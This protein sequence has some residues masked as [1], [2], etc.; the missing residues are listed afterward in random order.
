MVDEDGRIVEGR[1]YRHYE[2]G[3]SDATKALRALTRAR[4]DLVGT[5]LGLAN[6]LRAQLGCF[7]A[8]AA[9]VFADID[10]P[11]ALAFLK[12]YP[13]PVDARGLGEQRMARFLTRHGYS[14]RRTP[15]RAAR[16]VA[17]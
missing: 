6:E 16:A 3:D 5:R 4:E 12:R 17:Q 1:R 2:R 9:E 14:G 10:S 8:G 13:S 11:I 7:W 15:G